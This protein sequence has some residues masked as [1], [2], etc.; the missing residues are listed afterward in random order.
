MPLFHI[1]ILYKGRR[2]P[3]IRG[4]LYASPVRNGGLS[5]STSCL[6]IKGNV[7]VETSKLCIIDYI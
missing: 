5:K 3:Q 2:M 1:Y 4:L 6:T 7:N